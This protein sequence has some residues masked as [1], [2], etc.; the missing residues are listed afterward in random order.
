[1]GIHHQELGLPWDQP[2]PEELWEKVAE[3]CDNDVIATE[4]VFNYTKG[5]FEARLILTKLANA[6]APNIKSVP[7]DTTNTLTG[8]IVFMGDKHPQ[9]EFV[10]TDFSTGKQYKGGEQFVYE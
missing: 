8:R 5:D 4:A 7:N 2:V 9:R 6:F 10:Y 3:Y 1:M